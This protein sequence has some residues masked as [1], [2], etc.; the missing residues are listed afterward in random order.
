ME[1]EK[2]KGGRERRG[3]EVERERE[4]VAERGEGEGKGWWREGR[5]NDGGE[6]RG[7]RMVERGK[8]ERRGKEVEMKEKRIHLCW[9]YGLFIV[10]PLSALANVWVGGW[11]CV[12]SS[13]SQSLWYVNNGPSGAVCV[14][15]CFVVGNLSKLFE[16]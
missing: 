8:G 15:V 10:V 6:R 5:E 1:R 12:N 11:E 9:W 2:E 3:K 16:R 4:K 7:K 13:H 14:C